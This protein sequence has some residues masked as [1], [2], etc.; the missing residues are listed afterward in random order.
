LLVYGGENGNA[1]GTLLCKLAPT[2]PLDAEVPRS[3]KVGF[4]NNRSIQIAPGE[5]MEGVGESCHGEVL[6]VNCDVGRS[7]GRRIWRRRGRYAGAFAGV[8]R[9]GHLWLS[10]AGGEDVSRHRSRAG[11]DDK[12]KTVKKQ[13]AKHQLDVIRR[14]PG[15]DFGAD[16]V[17][18]ALQPGRASVHVGCIHAVCG[19][20]KINHRGLGEEVAVALDGV[21]M[22]ERVRG[23]RAGVDVGDEEGLGDGGGL[24]HRRD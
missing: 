24:S 20:D 10:Q 6:T 19:G 18:I 2:G 7:A 15:R 4:V 21:A 9:L 11:F 22:H 13:S 5:V 12:V 1:V 16:V 23:E 17:A 3:G 14:G 8:I